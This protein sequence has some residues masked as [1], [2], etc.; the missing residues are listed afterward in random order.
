MKNLSLYCNKKTCLFIVMFAFYVFCGM[1]ISYPVSFESNIFFSADNQRAFSDLMEIT[2][3]H[4]RIKVHPAFL[5]LAEAP[6]LV[7][8]G[9]VNHQRMT[10]IIMEA[11]CGSMS[12]YVFYS[13]LEKKGV[14]LK[15]RSLT[16][17]IYAF[18]FSHLIFS[19]V[20]ETYIFANLGLI[21][22]W[23]FILLASEKQGDFNKKEIFLLCFFGC[24]SFGITLTN[25]CSYL[26]GLVYLTS[27]RY[28]KKR[29]I[30]CFLLINIWLVS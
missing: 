27:R 19:T 9:I 15:V 4:Y 8:D 18:S 17:A 20:P 12:A 13:I 14:D 11:F 23:Y 6:A 7:L 5:F 22:Y 10:V 30:K 24:I 3:N 25:Y 21:S 2:G 29:G 1:C 16:T 28:K 26:V